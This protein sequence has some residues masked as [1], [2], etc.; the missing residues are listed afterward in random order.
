MFRQVR[1]SP[2][3]SKLT[4]FTLIECFGSL[5]GDLFESA[6]RVLVVVFEELQETTYFAKRFLVIKSPSS[7]KVP[8]ISFISIMIG[9]VFKRCPTV[10]CKVDG[11][12]GIVNEKVVTRCG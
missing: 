8:V 9:Y 2:R 12:R 11:P 7:S 5:V 6:S 1:F 3:K 4:D 10:R